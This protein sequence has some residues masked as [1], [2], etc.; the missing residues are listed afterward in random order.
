MEELK[1]KVK[2]VLGGRRIFIFL[3]VI[4][5]C[6]IPWL[7]YYLHGYIDG[8]E[9]S[10]EG[11]AAIAG[12]G[13]KNEPKVEM[14][15]RWID[16]VMVEK[17]K[18]NLFPAAIMIENHV[19]ARPQSGLTKA[20]LVY[21]AEAEGGITRFLAIYASG[22]E[23][24]KIGP[25]RSARPYYIDWSADLHALYIHCGGSPDAL[26]KIARENIFDLN[27]FYNTAAFWREKSRPAPHNVYSSS[28]LISAY[29]DK[30]EADISQKNESAV[31]WKYKDDLEPLARPE[32][33]A[34]TVFYRG[35]DFT[36]QWKYDKITNDYSRF[37]GGLAH[38]M[39]DGTP[40]K[41]KNIIIQ[42]VQSRV[43]DEEGRRQIETIG[44]GKAKICLDGSCG[45]GSW[46]KKNKSGRTFY[47]NAAGEEIEFNAGTTWVEVIPNG[48]KVNAE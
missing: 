34:I 35:N 18:E 3:G 20:N 13:E 27:E 14:A 22:D 40:I 45:D 4:I 48:Y 24:K 17:G 5:F 23:I 25:I 21:E 28:G 31:S 19:D 15:R 16:G 1:N 39:E 2:A 7:G 47:Y 8:S 42:S 46:K 41:A 9:K 38:V 10:R 12:S 37:E 29:L 32:D 44:S 26:A 30:S 6:L 36:V 11:S 33:S 43:I